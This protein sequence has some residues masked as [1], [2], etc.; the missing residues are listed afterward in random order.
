MTPRSLVEIY[1]RFEEHTAS[2]FSVKRY[3]SLVCLAYVRSSETSVKSLPNCTAV[4]P[5]TVY[6]RAKP[7][8]PSWVQDLEATPNKK[9]AAVVVVL[10]TPG[11]DWRSLGLWRRRS[12]GRRRYT[13][14]NRRRGT[15][16]RSVGPAVIRVEPGLLE[17]SS[18]ADGNTSADVTSTTTDFSG[19][20]H[21][22][23]FYTHKNHEC[24]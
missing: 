22:R 8:P 3:T 15:G 13:R 14:W 19:R 1:W 20:S 23:R 6:L 16:R 4:R 5:V 7:R 10:T 17:P 21:A 9:T 24:V 18:P 12:V 2:I 11:G